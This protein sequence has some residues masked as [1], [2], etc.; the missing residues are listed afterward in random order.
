METSQNTKNGPLQLEM[1]T[2]SSA[3][4][5]AS[6]SASPASEKEW[7]IRVVTW[8]S[9]S[10]DLLTTYGRNGS[11]GKTSLE[12]CPQIG[13]MISPPSS[14]RWQNSGTV[15]AG[16]C[17]THATSE[18]RNVAVES[19]LSRTLETGVLPQRFYLS[20]KACAGILRRAARRGKD[21]PPMLK[22]ALEETAMKEPMPEL[23]VNVEEDTEE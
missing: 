23:L 6:L 18:S 16:E 9:S 2:S 17:L 11:S 1:W 10:L 13:G 12:S 14:G 3:G 5:H 8:P 21:L 15:H 22:K 7:L 20:P 19:S 4:P